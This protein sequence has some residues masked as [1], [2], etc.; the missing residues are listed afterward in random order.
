MSKIDNLIKLVESD[1]NRYFV[2]NGAWIDYDPKTG[3]CSSNQPGWWGPDM[4]P[5]AAYRVGG[6]YFKNYNEFKEKLDIQKVPQLRVSGSDITDAYFIIFGGRGGLESE[7]DSLEDRIPEDQLDQFYD[8][9]NDDDMIE[10]VW[11]DCIGSTNENEILKFIDGLYG[12]Q[13][14]ED[15]WE[16]MERYVYEVCGIVLE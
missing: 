2:G 1:L 11:K 6:K 7:I 13:S 16:A 14:Q 4:H 5:L 3:Y 10:Y 15:V 8:K 9:F 12:S